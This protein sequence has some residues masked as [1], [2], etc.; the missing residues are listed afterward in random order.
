M[1]VP[2][3]WDYGLTAE[4]ALKIATVSL[5]WAMVDSVLGHMLA[6]LSGIKNL[7]HAAELVHVLDLKK[8]IE[9]LNGRKKRGELP[10]AAAPLVSEMVFVANNYRS[11]RNMLAHGTYA[12]APDDP[13]GAIFWSQSKLK[14]LPVSELDAILA[15]ARYAAH[16]AHH[17]MLAIIAPG[18]PATPLPARPPTRPAQP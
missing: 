10:A 4:Q 17:L 2:P 13:Q 7:Q 6:D 14:M 18:F 9:L 3:M 5:D 15:E 16:V 12:G 11:G 1:T 8:K